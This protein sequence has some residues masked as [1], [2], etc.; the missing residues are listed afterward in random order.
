M[1]RK[2][3]FPVTPDRTVTFGT[4]LKHPLEPARR[5]VGLRHGLSR[6]RRERSAELFIRAFTLYYPSRR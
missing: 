6:G 2:P 4:N 1:R 3:P 5:E